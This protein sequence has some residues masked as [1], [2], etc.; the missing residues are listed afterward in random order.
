MSRK[1]GHRSFTA[2]TTAL[3]SAINISSAAYMK[4]YIENVKRAVDEGY[5]VLGY[6]YWSLLD[7]FEWTEGYR[8]RFGLIHVDFDT[9]KR[10]P[11]DS[12]A[13]YEKVIETNGG[14]L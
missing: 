6:Q 4:D 7:N 2:L 1:M 14:A 8:P 9:R 3:L 13:Y 10:T 5:P 12:A 11:K